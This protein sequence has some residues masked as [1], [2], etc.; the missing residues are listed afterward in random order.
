MPLMNVEEQETIDLIVKIL[1]DAHLEVKVEHPLLEAGM[2]VDVYA[3]T[4]KGQS[5]VIEVKNPIN[6]TKS[7]TDSVKRTVSV[8]KKIAGINHVFMVVSKLTESPAPNIVNLEK[9]RQGLTEILSEENAS[10][11]E[12]P[13]RPVE[14][15]SQ[16][17]S[18]F[19]VAMP[20]EPKFDD[21]FNVGI[22]GAVQQVG[23]V[24]RR[25]DQQIAAN[26]TIISKIQDSIRNSFG[27]IA[28]CTNANAN[29]CYEVGF[30]MALDKPTIL[31]CASVID[32]LP[33]DLKCWTILP[34]RFG[35]T[36]KLHSDLI[37]FL[38]EY[39]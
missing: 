22:R 18:E 2:I 21:T 23:C 7:F 19:F 10:E 6:I 14:E 28:D 34:Y 15:S 36:S 1:Q 29:V 26:K 16:P 13:L 20:F 39:L 31:I 25:V 11:V 32:K 30:A 38:K 8:Y 24:C 27:V 37:P 35:Q 17:I 3:T 4:P 12:Y 5:I 9:F 33:F